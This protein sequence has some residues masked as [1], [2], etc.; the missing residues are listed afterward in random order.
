MHLITRSAV[1]FLAASGALAFTTEIRRQVNDTEVRVQISSQSTET[2][3]QVGFD[4][5]TQRVYDTPGGASTLFETIEVF[6]GTGAQQDLRCQAVGMR[7]MP[8]VATRGENTYVKKAVLIA[9]IPELF[10]DTCPQRRHLCIPPQT[11][12]ENDFH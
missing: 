6:V 9:H 4:S 11:R 8:L 2:G 12:P 7:G 5:V 10:A 1:T 3:V